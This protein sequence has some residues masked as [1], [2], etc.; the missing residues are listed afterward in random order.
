VLVAGSAVGAVLVS[1]RTARAGRPAGL[2][3]G[4]AVGAAGAAVVVVAAMMGS[5]ALALAG[6]AALGVANSAVYLSRYAA[7]DLVTRAARG[8]AMGGVLFATAVGAVASPTLLGPSGELAA[9]LGL[10]RLS[11]LYLVALPAFGGAAGLL[12]ALS[13]GTAAIRHGGEDPRPG[14]QTAVRMT[15]EALRGRARTAALVLGVTN[16]VMVAVMAITPVHLTSHHHGLELVGLVVSIHVLCMF[17]PSPLTGWLT[18][19]LGSTRVVSL[20]GALL[21]AS[22]LTG[23]LLDASSGPAMV[24]TLGLLGLGWNAGVVGGS[25]M[26]TTSVP[27]PL[28]P[29][30]EAIGEIAM[31]AAAA[32]SAPLAGVVTAQGGFTSLSLAGAFLAAAMLATAHWPGRSQAGTL[33]R[34]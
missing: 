28:R 3:L 17:A 29:R 20:G 9:A 1:R 7:A 24:L 32:A 27:A 12:A 5:L 11:G 22:G 23:A 18:D 25:T 34:R 16:L 30:T 4:Y 33:T 19:R 15:A 8:R 10:P 13:R 21:I 14:R 26:L 2:V 31:G 6:S